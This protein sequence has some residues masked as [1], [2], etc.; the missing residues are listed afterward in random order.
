MR[1]TMSNKRPPRSRNGLVRIACL[2]RR[3]HRRASYVAPT[4]WMWLG[5]FLL[6]G[7]ASRALGTLQGSAISLCIARKCSPNGSAAAGRD[8]VPAPVV[9]NA[10][11]VVP[12]T[13]KASAPTSRIILDICRLPH[14]GG[15]LVQ[16]IGRSAVP[17]VTS[18]KRPQGA[19][20]AAINQEAW[21]RWPRISPALGTG[22]SVYLY[23]PRPLGGG[24]EA[25]GRHGGDSQMTR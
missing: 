6:V 22:V 19:L 7:G 13:A 25:L 16:R 24:L 1:L 21:P 12:A 14:C 2:G 23:A 3:H 11:V 17:E 5:P 15:E 10:T 20:S 4:I 8:E 9:R 18:K